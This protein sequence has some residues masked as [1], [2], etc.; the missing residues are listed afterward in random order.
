MQN[1]PT[2]SGKTITTAHALTNHRIPYFE[3]KHDE[4]KPKRN[5]PKFVRSE[6]EALERLWS[7]GDDAPGPQYF[8]HKYDV[9]TQDM[10]VPGGFACLILMEKLVGITPTDEWYW[11]R[12]LQERDEIR[13]A[14]KESYTK[15]LKLGI[16]HNDYALRNLIWNPDTRKCY[17]IDFEGVDF[18]PQKDIPAWGFHEVYWKVW[19]L[20]G[21]S[22]DK[23]GGW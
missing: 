4:A 6:V 21:K 8:S 20:R 11:S 19:G 13:D 5:A 18:I 17:I 15:L 14:F 3:V 7:A 1:L 23:N 10:W 2:V 16:D 22:L 12:S 9:Q